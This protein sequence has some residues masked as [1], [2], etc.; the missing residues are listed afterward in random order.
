MPDKSNIPNRYHAFISPSLRR[1]FLDAQEDNSRMVIKYL[2]A[3][4]AALK[5]RVTTLS[6]DRG[7]LMDS[8]DD[9][10]ARLRAEEHTVHR[11]NCKARADALEIDR[12]R[13]VS[14]I[15]WEV[16]TWVNASL[17]L[18]FFFFFAFLKLS[19]KLCSWSA[20]RK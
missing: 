7:R 13:A 1:V 16:P 19:A 14:K 15:T 10:L 8:R 17:T 9:A 4:I 5:K 11:A 3:E 18:F 20:G 2:N 6:R 12:L